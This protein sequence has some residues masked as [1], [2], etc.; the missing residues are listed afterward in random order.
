MMMQ[1][2]AEFSHLKVK[3]GL[4]QVYEYDA[5]GK[6]QEFS[7]ILYPSFP[8]LVLED[9]MSCSTESGVLD[10]SRLANVQD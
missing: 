4:S 8:V 3:I 5:R 1:S 2:G 9:P 6:T 7:T 10:Q